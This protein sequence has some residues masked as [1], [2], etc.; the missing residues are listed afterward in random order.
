MTNN[1]KYIDPRSVIHIRNEEDPSQYYNN[2]PEVTPIKKVEHKKVKNK[3]TEKIKKVKHPE[4]EKK[5][6]PIQK[7]K[8]VAEN[9]TESEVSA[10]TFNKYIPIDGWYLTFVIFLTMFGLAMLYSAW[11]VKQDS[12]FY[13]QLLYAGAGIVLMLFIAKNNYNILKFRPIVF[14][15][16]ITSVVLLIMVLVSGIELNQASRWLKIGPITFQPSEVTKLGVI[17]Y[18]AFY[19]DKYNTRKMKPLES[20]LIYMQHIIILGAIAVLLLM[21]PHLSGMI[22]IGVTAIFMIIMSGI[23]WKWI[24][25]D[26]FAGGALIY[27]VLNF[28]TVLQKFAAHFEPR[29]NIWKDPFSDPLHMGFQTVQSLYAIGSGGLFGLGFGGSREKHFYLPEANNDYIFSVVCEELGLIGALIVIIAFAA[30]IY[31]G[32]WIALHAKDKH[33]SMLAA[34]ISTAIAVQVLLNIAVVTNAIPVTGISLPFFSS[35]GTAL[36]ILFVEV[37]IVLSVSRQIQK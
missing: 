31:R 20:G 10:K 34:G 23:S 36:L 2:P 5:I 35:G 13:Q 19:I 27:G 29:V 33:G 37:G 11:Y 12:G 9:S 7:A 16:I 22:I 6:I 28:T 32:F 18:F 25:A 21:Q 24:F 26:I 8:K 4:Q 15:A 1:K 17:I 30:L 3:K 14:V